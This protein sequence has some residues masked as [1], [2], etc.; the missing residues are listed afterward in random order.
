MLDDK[1]HLRFDSVR[2]LESHLRMVGLESEG[3]WLVFPKPSLKQSD[4]TWETIVESCLCFGWIDSLSGKVDETLTKIYISPRKPK[5]GWSRRNQLLVEQLRRQGRVSEAGNFMIE[6]ARQD[7]SWHL[8]D[9]AEDLVIPD[10]LQ[11]AF[12]E[13]P[14]IFDGWMR[15]TTS[16]QKQL[17]QAFYLL[18]SDAAKSRGVEKIALRCLEKL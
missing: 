13:D 18:K 4:L 2:D 15:F 11:T 9:L 16:Q 3:F 14:K 8:F 5:S 7:G 17:L 1:T 12:D 10:Q 6:R